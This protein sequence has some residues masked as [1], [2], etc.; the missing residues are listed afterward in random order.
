MNKRLLIGAALTLVVVTGALFLLRPN[1]EYEKAYVR[2]RNVTAWSRVAAVRAPVVN[3]RYGEMVS[4]VE[5]QRDHVQIETSDGRRGWVEA[6]Q[7][8]AAEM[9]RETE[10]LLSRTKKLEVYARG[11]TKRS[12][13]LRFTPGRETQLLYQLSGEVPVEIVGREVVGWTQPAPRT[14]KQN[15]RP[16]TRREDWYLVRAKSEEAGDL[17][18]WVLGRFIEPDVPEPLQQ[19]GAGIRWMAW[20]ELDRVTDEDRE[21]KQYLGVGQ[22]GAEGQPCDFTVMRV[23]TWS[24]KRH[25]YETAYVESSLCGSV[26]IRFV[27]PGA[28][29]V[30]TFRNI[31]LG[32]EEQREYRYQ[33][34]LVRRVRK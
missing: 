16:E 8:M 29:M 21:K 32:G 26:P 20:Y 15:Q 19:L 18:G 25:R 4:V 22:V 2:S 10:Q 31:A 12:T 1:P 13:N 23:Y 6:R 3:L 14:G 28:E 5:R 9:W 34:N 30:F 17:A 11:K 7:L 24:L 27:R 33:Q